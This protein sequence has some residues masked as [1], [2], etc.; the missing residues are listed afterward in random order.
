MRLRV[1]LF[2]LVMTVLLACGGSGGSGSPAPYRG[3]SITPSTISLKPNESIQLTAVVDGGNQAVVWSLPGVGPTSQGSF[4]EP[5]KYKAPAASG[6]Y[7]IRAEVSG[8]P[9]K[10]AEAVAKVDSG[11]VVNISSAGSATV[12][13]GGTKTF[14]ATVTGAGSSAV[15][16][17]ATLGTI[18]V[19]GVYTAPSGAVGTSTFTDTITA[20]S[21]LDPS[22]KQTFTVTVAPAIELVAFSGTRYAMPLSR[23]TFQAKVAGTVAT[24]GVNWSASSG[25]I[26][27]AGV[28]TGDA[29][30][31]GDVTVTATLASDTSKSVSTTISVRTDLMVRFNFATAGSIS[32]GLRPDKAPRHC[33]N[34][35][36]LVNEK[37]YEGIKLHR[38]EENF[39]VQWGCPL[40]KTL[41]LTDPSI[42]TGGPGY[43]INF[44][45][46]DLKHLKYSLG[47]ARS[48]SLDSAGSQIYVCLDD[49]KSLD[50]NYVVFGSVINGEAL[51]D[52]I[53]VGD[54]IT[55][56]T[57][58]PVPAP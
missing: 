27:S 6:N 40:T 22:K 16:W 38:R 23:Q 33:A 12:A 8:E 2:A 1:L 19:S 4:T 3:I 20:T 29:T 41:P 30:T 39:V 46:N 24:S 18:T 54:T 58:E 14:S 45:A 51:I 56:A 9:T 25:T 31:L 37:F 57:V 44:E 42:G 26:T 13:Y 21:A 10:F 17:T 15:T 34:L 52:A 49:L 32:L 48:T 5:G 50:G 7:T 43:T 11:Y 36:S 47:M 55:S 28:W 53:Q 35:V